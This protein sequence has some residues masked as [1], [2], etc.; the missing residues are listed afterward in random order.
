MSNKYNTG[1]QSIYN[2][3]TNENGLTTVF[4]QGIVISNDDSNDGGRIKV[5][6][7]GID[8]ALLDSELPYAFPLLQ[9]FFSVTPKKKEVVFIFV[10]NTNNPYTDRLFIGPI[11]S[12][13]QMLSKDSFIGGAT[14][15]LDSGFMEPKTAPSTIPESKGSFPNIEDVSIQGRENSDIIFKKNEVIIRAGKFDF[16][17]KPNEIPK[18]NIKNPSFIQIK[19]SEKFNND[20]FVNIVS[21]KINLLTHENGSPRFILNDQDSMINDDTLRAIIEKAH[22]MVFGDL[23][24]E[25]LELMRLAIIN[26][27]HSYHGNKAQ[28]LSGANDLKKFLE[29]DVNK[30]LS[31]NIKIN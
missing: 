12:Q 24:I 8:D 19:H 11:V 22:P 23:L 7:K 26:H 3:K 20:G 9:K 2:G 30:I 16:N 14:S 10:A 21:N 1:K 13:P 15:M 28:D 25:Y 27:V 18:F 6:I 5:R 29:F 31:K 4:Y 17:T